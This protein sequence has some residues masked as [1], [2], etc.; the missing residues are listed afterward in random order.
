[1]IMFLQ[2]VCDA[3]NYDAFLR[4]IFFCLFV[5]I[6]LCRST[7]RIYVVVVLEV[8]L[9]AKCFQYLIIRF[10]FVFVSNLLSEK[11]T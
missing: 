9:S 4:R 6:V 1:M 7:F 5:Q 2:I 8:D 3:I 10:G 11:I